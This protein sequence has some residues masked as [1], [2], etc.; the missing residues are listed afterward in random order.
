MP[1]YATC[2]WALATFSE[3]LE[4]LVVKM[5]ALVEPMLHATFHGLGLL[6]ASVMDL[7]AHQ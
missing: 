6:K 4:M 5:P 1:P 3:K 7:Q 2:R